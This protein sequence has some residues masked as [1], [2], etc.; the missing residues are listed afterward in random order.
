M[1]PDKQLPDYE[2]LAEF[3]YHIRRFLTAADEAARAVG[4]EPEQYQLLLALHGRTVRE[5]GTIRALAERLQVRHN[6]AV[7]RLDRMAAMGLLR[8]A[9]DPRDRRSVTI[10]VT[11]RGS[12]LFEKLARAR[13]RELRESGPALVESLSRV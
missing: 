5:S 11:A 12:R 10:R 2:A 8:R 4:L 9:R 1:R 7:E 13:L 3:R 6:T